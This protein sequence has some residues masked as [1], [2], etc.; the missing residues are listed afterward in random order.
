VRCAVGS[1]LLF[2]QT[3]NDIKY[4]RYTDTACTEVV[5][6]PYDTTKASTLNLKVLDLIKKMKIIVL[7]AALPAV[8]SYKYDEEGV[9]KRYRLLFNSYSTF[10]GFLKEM[11][12]YTND[13]G[14]VVSM[15]H[16]GQKNFE[17]KLLTQLL[18]DAQNKARFLGLA[19]KRPVRKILQLREAD[20]EE[21]ARGWTVYPPLSYSLVGP[22]NDKIVLH[23]KSI[24]RFAW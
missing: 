23:K 20:G 14:F 10:T 5:Q 15:R 8:F 11:E 1:H 17:E 4:S 7:D 21:F 16:S 18:V 19:A 6:P 24:V 9:L 3:K 2:I 13:E 22:K 12:S